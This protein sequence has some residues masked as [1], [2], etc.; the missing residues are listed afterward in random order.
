MPETRRAIPF[1]RMGTRLEDPV[2]A[3]LMADALNR[4]D[5][6]SLGAGFTDTA[7]LPADYVAAAYERLRQQS[8]QPD[9]LQYGTN[10]GRAPL[11]EAIAEHLRG[12]PDE[13]PGAFTGERTLVTNGSQQGL[14]LAMQVLCDPGDEVWVE[15]PSYFVF[16][17]LLKGLG[18]TARSLPQSPDGRIDAERLRS[19]LAVRPPKAIYLMGY[20]ANPS[21]RSIPEEDKRAL[22]AAIA[23]VAPETVVIEDAA[24]REMYFETPWPAR[25]ILSLP[26]F[27]SLTCLYAG[28]LTKPFATGLKIGYVTGNEPELLRAM[29]RAKAH[30][31]FGTSHFTQAILEEVLKAGDFAR[32]L[33]RVRPLYRARVRALED[34][35]RQGGLPEAGWHWETPLGGLMLWASG[36]A[37]RD[38]SQQG[39][40]CRGCLE[41]GV[42]YVPGDLCFAE[43]TPG[44]SVRLSVGALDETGLQEAAR[45]F[46]S[47]AAA[48]S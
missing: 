14:Y 33:E 21:S 27:E 40:F 26:E 6:L 5:L 2:I 10:W 7:S 24:Y 9:Y 31:D 39:T 22:G 1:S 28:T 36:P 12:F 41:A 42:L 4:P 11:R 18:I 44:N 43:G 15:A 37:E 45:R 8:P 17:E 35:L 32:S 3:G 19:E 16:L 13:M 30:H 47:V 46:C 38:T 34:A 20:F 29:G 25:S 23:E 48:R